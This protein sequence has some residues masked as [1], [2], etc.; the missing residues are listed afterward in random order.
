MKRFGLFALVICLAAL[1]LNGAP[2]LVAS[3]GLD[4]ARQLNQ[5]F[6]EVADKVSPA[7]VVITVMQKSDSENL[8]DSNPRD[9]RRRSRRAFPSRRNMSS[10]KVRV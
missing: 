3:P 6:A 2:L 5:A 1:F 8:D 7:V 10:V 9:F 4:L